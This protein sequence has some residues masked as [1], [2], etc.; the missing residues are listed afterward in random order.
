MKRVFHHY[1][2]LEENTAGMWRIVSGEALKSY[3]DAAADLMRCPE[4]FKAAMVSALEAWPNSCQH[5]LTAE[6]VNRIAWLGH[7]GCCIATSSPEACTRLG[8]HMLSK[9]EQDEANRVAA[10]VL[11]LWEKL[12]LSA[13]VYDL[14]AHGQNNA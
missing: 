9:P 11:E 12:H 6:S 3:R 1:S 2:A 7:A 8:W 14:F 4:E 13:D 5:N 10:E